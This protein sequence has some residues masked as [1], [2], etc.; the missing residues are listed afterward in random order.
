MQPNLHFNKNS[1]CIVELNP[2]TPRPFV[3]T[4]VAVCL[5]DSIQ[6]AGFKTNYLIN[7][8]DPTSLSIILGGTPDA[9]SKLSN[10]DPERCA[11]VNLEQLGSSSQMANEEYIRWLSK[12]KVIEYHNKNVEYL[13]KING[14]SQW[15]AEIPIVPSPNLIT[16]GNELPSTDVL[17]YGTPSPRRETVLKEIESLGLKVERVIGAYGL[18][19]AS[20][21]RRSKIVLH[22]HFYETKLCPVTRML[23][24]AMMGVPIV[25][26]SSFF[27]PLNDWS[28]S[29]IILSDYNNLAKT[30]FDLINDPAKQKLSVDSVKTFCKNLDFV[31]PFT[32]LINNFK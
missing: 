10:I 30:C 12:W 3:F 1:I 16:T 24:P 19:L 9:I 8:I 18:E 25:C 4:E 27:S 6:L 31:G 32:Q 14:D 22:V 13:K 23:Q 7:Q 29:G 2:Y 11:I 5:R 21:I 28:Q 15:V 17:F 26:E 20:A